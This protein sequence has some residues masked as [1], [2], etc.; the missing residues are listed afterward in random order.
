MNQVGDQVILLATPIPTGSDVYSYVW[1]FWDNSSAAT[2]QPFI[3][4]VVNMGGNPFND[5]L[6]YRCRPV[7]VDGQSDTVLG[8]ITANQPPTILPGVSISRND[9]YFTYPTRLSLTAIDID[10]DAIGFSWYQGTNYI[11]SGT[12]ASAGSAN[13]T[14][15]GP[16]WYNGTTIVVSRPATECYYDLLVT[17]PRTVTCKVYDVR[18]GTSSVDF[19]LRGDANRP[20]DASLTA[21]VNGVAFDASTPVQARIGESQQLTFSVFV[22]PM[23]THV[24]YFDWSFSGSNHWTMAPHSVNGTTTYLAN[25]A[26]QNTVERD[27]SAEVVT[28][29][30]AKLARVDVRVY[31]ENIYDS[32]VS[33]TDISYSVLLIENSAPSAVTVGRYDENN[34]PIDTSTGTGTK[35]LFTATGTD[36]NNDWMTYEWAFS[37]TVP[38]LPSPFYCWGPKVVFDTTGAV[39]D[40]TLEGL[41]TVTDVLGGKLIVA[42]PSTTLE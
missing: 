7:A 25:G 35:I 30:T 21:G 9:E 29:G 3:T 14:W 8:Y 1:D 39:V 32:R 31:A 10:G 22:G 34:L 26:I 37:H 16:E 28:S 36:Y 42:L 19:L 18:G 27:I 20:P 11:G 13:G 6:S 23:P 4:K 33:Y 5:V 15:H 17:S 38:H 40:T 12:T 2:S 41:L 24:V